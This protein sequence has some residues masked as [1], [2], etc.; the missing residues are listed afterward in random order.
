LDEV[1]VTGF[2]PYGGFDENPS[3]KVAM[4]MDGKI[5]NGKRVKGVILPVSFKKAFQVLMQYINPEKPPQIICST[6]LDP[7]ISAL[8]IEKIAL[9]IK[10]FQ[11]IPDN[12][13][14]RPAGEPIIPGAPLALQTDIPVEKIY[15]ELIANDIPA[16]VSYHAGTHLCNYIFYNLLYIKQ[17]YN[18]RTKICFTHLPFLVSQY[19][20][21]SHIRT[22]TPSLPLDTMV[23]GI[24]I[25]IKILN[26]LL[27]VE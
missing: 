19:A 13:G 5:I 12:D 21:I 4:A 24:S 18:W 16:M 27:T 17:K 14:E 11:G 6:G 2:E 3:M 10:D 15:S 23:K 25:I 9:N 8:K 22:F 7:F 20:K 26:M 1:I